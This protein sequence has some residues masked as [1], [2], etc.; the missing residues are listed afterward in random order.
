M[1]HVLTEITQLSS[2]LGG[3]AGVVVAMIAIRERHRR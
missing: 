1:S 3:L 2:A